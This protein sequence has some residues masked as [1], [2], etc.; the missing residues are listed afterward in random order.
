[1]DEEE[2]KEREIGPM[3]GGHI[4]GE[5]IIDELLRSSSSFT[6]RL[7]GKRET[8]ILYFEKAIN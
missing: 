7:V 5:P 4:K 2:L 6:G 8:R 3:T 1:M